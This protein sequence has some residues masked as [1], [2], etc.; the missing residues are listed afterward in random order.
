[1]RYRMGACLGCTWTL[2]LLTLCFSQTKPIASP[3]PVGFYE[4]RNHLTGDPPMFRVSL[5]EQE[6]AILAMEVSQFE[7]SWTRTVP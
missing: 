2:L 5:P 4:V 1:M 6:S 7:S 3:V